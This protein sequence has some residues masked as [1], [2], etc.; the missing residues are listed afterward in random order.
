MTTCVVC[1]DDV[2]GGHTLE[3]GHSFHPRCLIQWLREGNPSCPHCREDLR[4]CPGM[5]QPLLARARTVTAAAR[6]KTAPSQLKKMVMHVKE[7]K[8]KVKDISS[9]LRELE[10]EHK[11]VFRKVNVLQGRMYL[12]RRRV[13]DA[14]MELG[15]FQMPGMQLPL[16]LTA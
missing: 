2:E 3:C 8:Q 13:R 11:E 7:C 5:R 1:F 15:L 12:A 16:L 10:R 6:R 4:S 14:I 9:T